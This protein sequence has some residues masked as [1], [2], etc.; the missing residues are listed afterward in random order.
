M[1]GQHSHRYGFSMPATDLLFHMYFAT[2][3]MLMDHV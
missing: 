3:S 2:K 1:F